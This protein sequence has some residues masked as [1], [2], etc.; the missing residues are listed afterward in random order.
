MATGGAS[1]LADSCR[2]AAVAG[3]VVLMLAIIAMWN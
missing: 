2:I 1:A 3:S